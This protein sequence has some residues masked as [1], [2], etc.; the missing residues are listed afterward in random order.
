MTGSTV[1]QDFVEASSST[2]VAYRC[3]ASPQTLFHDAV[4]PPMPGAEHR[5]DLSHSRK[6]QRFW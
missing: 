5:A 4:P 1:V 3:P 2:Y 6:R